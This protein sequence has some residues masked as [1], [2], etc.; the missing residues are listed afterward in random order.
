MIATVK[1]VRLA[2]ELA[3]PVFDRLAALLTDTEEERP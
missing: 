3:G 2:P 1:G